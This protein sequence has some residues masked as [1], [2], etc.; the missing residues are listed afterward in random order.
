MSKS[1]Y[2]N[3]LL[4]MSGGQT[5]ACAGLGDGGC[6]EANYNYAQ[7]SPD[8]LTAERSADKGFKMSIYITGWEKTTKLLIGLTD[9]FLQ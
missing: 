2:V 9:K 3:V 6:W 5:E 8:T 1:H 7:A 4:G